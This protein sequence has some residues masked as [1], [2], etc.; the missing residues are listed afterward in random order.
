MRNLLKP[1]TSR[2]RSII[3]NLARAIASATS[4]VSHLIRACFSFNGQQRYESRFRLLDSL[5]R[6]LGFR[7]YNRNLYW[8]DDKEVLETVK[9]VNERYVHVPDRKYTLY[10]MALSAANLPGDSAECG[11][12]QGEGSYLICLA[13]ESSDQKV[14]HIFD[15]FEGLSSPIEEDLPSDERAYHWKKH[16]LAV[17]LDSVKTK[18]LRFKNVNFYKGWIPS[19]FSEVAQCKF[20]FVHID[21]DLYEP[22]LDSISFFYERMVPGG[23]ILCDDYGS[24]ICPGAKKAFDEFM[25]DKVEGPVIH[26]TTGQGFIIRHY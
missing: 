6:R 25:A 16:D 22:T 19:R 11:V 26:L 15:S 7:I 1:A 13:N 4:A 24:T 17:S 21:V 3:R 23:I 14:H 9:Q 20:S 5:T 10:S 8:V 2:D 12:F 18:L